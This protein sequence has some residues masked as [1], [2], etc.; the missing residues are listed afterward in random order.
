MAPARASAV[1]ARQVRSIELRFPLAGVDRR[2][3]FQDTGLRKEV[4]GTPWAVNCRSRDPLAGRMRGGSRPAISAGGSAIPTLPVT[5]ARGA[6][7]TYNEATGSSTA[8][9]AEVG[10][11]PESP[12]LGVLYRGRLVLSSANVLFA[13]RLGNFLDW[14]YGADAKDQSAAT[15]WQ[16][17]EA[18]EVGQDVTALVP[19]KDQVLIQATTGGIWS[20]A[21]DPVSGNLR[22]VTRNAGII[23]SSAWTLVDNTL[24]FMASNGLW[25]MGVDGSGMK[26]LSDEKIPGELQDLTGSAVVLAYNPKEHGVYIFTQGETY[27]WFYD[28]EAGAFWPMTMSS[29]PT[30]SAVVNGTLRLDCNG[31]AYQVG[32]TESITS[33]VLIGP[34][35]PAPAGNFGQ[36]LSIQGSVAEDGGDVTWYLIQGDTAQEACENGKLAM[37][38]SLGYVSAFGTFPA[39]RSLMSYPRTRSP[40]FTIWLS[41]SSAWAFESLLVEISQ[42]GRWR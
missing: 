20:L 3:A 27:Q 24:F 15:M 10:S 40:W 5:V 26:H 36:I 37:A 1:S 2:G 39:G 8:I 6:V 12:E 17:S 35:R 30:G 7:S 33:G 21:G 34:I 23:G 28:L 18:D 31:T 11:A 32:G 16:L 13:S 4:Y 42:A 19:F 41:S 9:I 38:G 25:S 22:N 14:D 29:V